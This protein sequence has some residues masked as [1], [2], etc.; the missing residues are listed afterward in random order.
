[1]VKLILNSTAYKCVPYHHKILNDVKFQNYFNLATIKTT[2][3][4]HFFEVDIIIHATII[5][6]IENCVNLT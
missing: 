3:L 2:F 5:Y 1:M 6:C 4:E